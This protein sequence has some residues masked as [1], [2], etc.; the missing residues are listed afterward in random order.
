MCMALSLRFAQACSKRIDD[1]AAQTPEQGHTPAA[2]SHR[3][4]L[5]KPLQTL[6]RAGS[7][8]AEHPKPL[9][10]RPAPCGCVPRQ[11]RRPRSRCRGRLAQARRRLPGCCPDSPQPASA[12]HTPAS[13]PADPPEAGCSNSFLLWNAGERSDCWRLACR[14]RQ[15]SRCQAHQAQ[16]RLP[17][18]SSHGDSCV[19]CCSPCWGPRDW[20]T[21]GSASRLHPSQAPWSQ[22]DGDVQAAAVQA[23]WRGSQASHTKGACSTVHTLADLQALGR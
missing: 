14:R 17:C 12:M 9:L 7:G 16:A 1:G 10:L 4:R 22:L 11:I 23:A 5:R 19:T 8:S 2:D 21:A 13:P 18:S 20:P 15:G 6:Q 3:C